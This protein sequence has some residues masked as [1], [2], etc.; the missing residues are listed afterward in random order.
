MENYFNMKHNKENLLVGDM[1]LLY[2]P[3]L[4]NSLPSRK[5]KNTFSGPFKIKKFENPV[6]VHLETLTNHPL[7]E[8]YH[9]NRLKKYY[10]RENIDV[11][12]EELEFKSL[13]DLKLSQKREIEIAKMLGKRIEVYW[14]EKATSLTG[15]YSATV[16]KYNY[17]KKMFE[18]RYDDDPV[19]TIFE[20][21]FGSNSPEWRWAEQ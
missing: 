7:K 13:S 8:L 10:E 5:L 4:K 18:L 2:S 21:L 15:W 1:V 12:K 20:K 16:E 9:I 19:D 3:N 6:L 11:D 17:Q 14:D